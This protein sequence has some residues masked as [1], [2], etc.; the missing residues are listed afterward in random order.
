MQWLVVYLSGELLL[1]IRQGAT[2]FFRHHYYPLNKLRDNMFIVQTSFRPTYRVGA[3]DVSL[4]VV[5]FNPLVREAYLETV[6][7]Q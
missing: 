2:V 5:E 6:E 4:N 3:L 7:G 1:E